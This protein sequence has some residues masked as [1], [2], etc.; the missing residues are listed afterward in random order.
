MVKTQNYNKTVAPLKN[1]APAAFMHI[2]FTASYF[3]Y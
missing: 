2:T 1:I 3:C